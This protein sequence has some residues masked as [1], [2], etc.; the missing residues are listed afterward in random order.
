MEPYAGRP[1][2][3]EQPTRVWPTLVAVIALLLFAITIPLAA[4]VTMIV[5]SIK[6]DGPTSAEQSAAF[7]AVVV[8]LISGI[9]AIAAG[10]ASVVKGTGVAR[11]FAVAAIIVGLL[12][13]GVNTLFLG[14]YLR[15]N[16]PASPPQS[17]APVCGPESHPT[18]F[19]GDSRYEVCPGDRK[20]AE[21]FAGNT[22]SALPTVDVT[23][24]SIDDFAS[25]LGNQPGYGGTIGTDDGLIAVWVPAPVTC[26]ILTWD[27]NAWS[28]EVTGMLADGGCVYLGG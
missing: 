2:Q 13:G 24:E 1:R 3:P 8:G 23:A 15:M 25:Q 12:A 9:V 10:I 16:A 17:Q 26:A 22:L 21:V 19:G 28:K 4:F 20:R 11:G 27:G 6:I 14:T 5:N 7:T 18:V